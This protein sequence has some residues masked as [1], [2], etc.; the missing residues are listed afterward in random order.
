MRLR[1]LVLLV[2]D[3]ETQLQFAAAIIRSTD[4]YDVA[5]AQ[6][7]EEALKIAEQS[8]PDLIISDNYLPGETGVEFCKRIKSHPFLRNTM[9]M[10]LTSER[11]VGHKILAVDLG[12]DEYVSKPYNSDELLT[13]VRAWVRIAELQRELASESEDLRWANELL[14][15]TIDGV[16]NLLARVIAI[17]VPNASARADIA[18]NM[19]RWM[20]ERLHLERDVQDQLELAARLHEIGKIA[21]PDEILKKQYRDLS[22]DEWSLLSEFALVSQRI[23]EGLSQFEEISYWMRHQLENHDGSGYPDKIRGDEIAMP[24]RILRAINFV[25]LSRHE[26]GESSAVF[27]EQIDRA[28][29]TILDPRVAQLLKEYIQVNEHSSWLE[30]KRQVSV[31]ELREGMVIASDLTTGSG[32]K[33]LPRDV[34][35]TGLHIERILAQHHHDPIVNSIFVYDKT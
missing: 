24:A 34:R 31:L 5:T 29:H 28:R 15:S 17:R 16:T 26:S 3:D 22:S 7:A 4:R 9:F 12:A 27:L 20:A 35:I 33:L 21:L 25:E 19:A 2:E 10:L 14:Q 32:M 8:K 23:M 18:A 6:T 1:P 30:G 11:E 13:R